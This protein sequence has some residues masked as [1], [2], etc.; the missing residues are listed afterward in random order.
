MIKN[1]QFNKLD[2]AQN[3]FFARELEF[4]KS[5]AYNV[6]Y[7]DLLGREFVPVSTE[8]P[9]GSKSVTYQQFDRKGKAKIIGNNVKDIP[10]VEVHGQEFTRPVR[11][12]AVAYGHNILDIRAAALAGLP[13]ESK[14]ALAAREAVEETIDEVAAIGS[15]SDGIPTGLLNDAAVAVTTVPGAEDWPTAIAAGSMDI[16]V[17]HFRN[18]ATRISTAGKG[19]ATDSKGIW[20]P[21]MAIISPE[22]YTLISSTEFGTNSDKT[23]LDF[24]LKAFPNLEVRSWNRMSTAGAGGIQRMLVYRRDARVAHQEIP[25]EFEQL[26]PQ[27]IGLEIVTN[28]L[29]QTAGTKVI[30]PL[31]LDYSDDI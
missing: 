15:P 29:A 30:Y 3:V 2:S 11:T 7:P 24:I 10:R 12:A 16:I 5:E 9:S 8:A 20:T 4:V 25:T 31:A 13:L 28:T 17:K 26:P 18:A 14:Y 19:L 6:E 22:R 23:I 21:N 1:Y 27:E